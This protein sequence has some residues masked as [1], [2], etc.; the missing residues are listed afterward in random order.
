MEKILKEKQ[1][2]ELSN[3]YF[4]LTETLKDYRKNMR[5]NRYKEM[6]EVQ[7]RSVKAQY[8]F[9]SYC[10]D[11]TVKTL[12]DHKYYNKDLLKNAILNRHV[13]LKTKIR[14]LKAYTRIP[15]RML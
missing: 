2:I 5:S 7:K 8:K 10:V 15:I 11:A 12:L 9:F 4:E 1:L 14:C 6:N 3:Q 13:C